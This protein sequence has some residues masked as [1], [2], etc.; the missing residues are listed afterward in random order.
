MVILSG[1]DK[2]YLAVLQVLSKFVRNKLINGINKI[3]SWKYFKIMLA[4][5]FLTNIA[6]LLLRS[7]VKSFQSEIR[8][9]NQ[10]VPR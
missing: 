10:G 7:K 4:M 8:Q 6:K 3:Q 5:N 1:Q 9:I 2:H